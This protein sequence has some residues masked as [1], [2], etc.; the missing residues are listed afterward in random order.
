MDTP[1]VLPDR[2]YFGENST[3]MILIED[4][5]GTRLFL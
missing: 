4:N 5:D 3:V 1:Q 2:I